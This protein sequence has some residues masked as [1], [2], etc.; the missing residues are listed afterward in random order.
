MKRYIAVVLIMLLLF[1]L[2]ACGDEKMTVAQNVDA[3]SLFR[4][5]GYLRY[6]NEE[7]ALAEPVQNITLTYSI[8][9]ASW[10][11]VNTGIVSEFS[12]E[13]KKG[14]DLSVGKYRSVIFRVGTGSDVITVQSAPNALG[15]NKWNAITAELDGNNGWIKLTINGVLAK[16]EAI[17]PGT[18]IAPADVKKRIGCNYDGDTLGGGLMVRN[19]FDG[20]IVEGYAEGPCEIPPSKDL[21]GDVNR[22]VFHATP[23]EKWMNEPHAPFFFNGKYHL[24]YQS[25]P[26]G[27]YFNNLNW[28][29]W[30]SD[31]M[32]NWAQMPVVLEPEYG[33]VSPDGCWSGG[34]TIAPNGKPLIFYT[35]GDDGKEPNQMVAL[36]RPADREDILLTQWVK[37]DTAI[38]TQDK[39]RMRP[40]E[41]R[42]PFV[43]ND[44]GQYWCVVGT[45]DAATGAGN[46]GV[47]RAL[48]DTLENWAF[49]GFL[50]DY[51]YI[52]EIGRVWELPVLLPIKSDS[53]DITHI[54]TVCACRIETGEPVKTYYWLGRFDGENGKFIPKDKTPRP[55]DSNALSIGGTGFVTPDERTVLFLIAQGKRSTDADGVAGYAH[56]AAIPLEVWAENAKLQIKPIDEV[57]TLRKDNFLSLTGESEAALNRA[58]EDIEDGEYELVFELPNQDFTLFIANK[59]LSYYKESADF[60][61]RGDAYS[62]SPAPVS[63]EEATITL[64]IIIDRSLVECFLG[65]HVYCATRIYDDNRVHRPVSLMMDGSVISAKAYNW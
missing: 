20:Y 13:A 10:E 61:F 42:D 1:T 22:P 50:M 23:P 2:A 35:A 9:P 55:I 52:P 8:A 48:D 53:A 32:V 34:S 57:D 4:Y 41:F 19:V 11:T 24:F 15:K 14:Y 64:R 31:D 63:I 49:T 58:L 60:G 62:G 38:I 25:N 56:C 12:T 17:P 44:N 46:A 28:G 59:T 36:A 16:E 40:G 51:G 18:V 7:P 21:A 37:D 29:H 3:A 65:E 39:N 47:Y 5:D 54:L 6:Q 43:F 45:G 26:H 30:V 27:P 33:T